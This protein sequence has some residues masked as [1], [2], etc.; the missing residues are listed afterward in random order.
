MKL[1]LHSALYRLCQRFAIGVCALLAMASALPSQAVV[2][3]NDNVPAATLLLPYFE[4]D[5][6]NGNGPQ[7]SVR[8][9]NASAT[10]ILA[11]VT[12][13]TD[14]G[15]PTKSFLIYLVGYDTA[16]IDLRLI[17]K[18]HLPR[19]ASDGQDP[20]DQISPQGNFSQDI[21]F[22]SCGGVLPYTT[23]MPAADLAALRNAHTGIA[24]TTFAG[25]CGGRVYG[26]G[27]ARGYMTIDTVNSCALM[28]PSVAGYF[29]SG[30]TG[31]ATNQN[32]MVGSYTTIDRSQG[33][34]TT[35]PLVHIEA[36][37]T[38]PISS[39]SGEPTFYGR[40]VNN[41]AVDNREPLG[42]IWNA[43]YL[44]GGTFTGGTHFIAWQDPGQVVA[45]AACGNTPTPFPLALG[46]VL[47]FNE[48]EDVSVSPPLST[49][50]SVSVNTV[51][52]AFPVVAQRV[53]TAPLSPFAFGHMIL[54]FN[55]FTGQSPT[56]S[57]TLTSRR[58]AF[59]SVQHSATGRFSTSTGAVR[60]QSADEPLAAQLRY[61]F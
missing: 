39:T 21:N 29:G 14:W 35:E 36:S 20:L 11:N 61:R 38:N 28:N 43:R 12:L 42:T 33:F 50:S 34:A 16:E 30:G 59:V 53:A 44:N 17:F 46:E 5:L 22:A 13:W 7:T 49:S 18:G 9:S 24:S 15:I 8:L 40:L 19:T 56:S 52:T 57:G 55:Q 26:D 23:L 48:Q 1:Y 10:A 51:N 47:A 31:V 27:R 41:T 54:N 2:G 4:V 6:N 58:Q 25:S 32:V 37:G 3:A 60:L 45:P